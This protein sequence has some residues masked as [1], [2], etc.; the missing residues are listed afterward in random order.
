MV[1]KEREVVGASEVGWRRRRRRPEIPPPEPESVPT[2]AMANGEWV[3]WCAL[4][5]GEGRREGERDI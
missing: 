3:R 4:C 1:A 2:D 5:S